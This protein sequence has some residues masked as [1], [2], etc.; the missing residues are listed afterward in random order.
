MKLIVICKNCR[1]KVKL[2]NSVSD[3]AELEREK[4]NKFKL[5]CNECLKEDCYHV[6]EVKAK[7]SKMIALIAF[8]IFVFGTGII[9]YLLRD[10]LFMPNN[11]YNVLAIGGLLLLPSTVY[12]IIT[13]QERESIRRFNQYRA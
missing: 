13:K 1:H 12:I 3:R 6:N 11:P 2:K 4:G 5:M 8:G 7:E 10:Y 9:G